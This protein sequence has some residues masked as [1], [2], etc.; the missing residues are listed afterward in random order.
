MLGIKIILD[1]ARRFVT[2]F[3]TSVFEPC[4]APAN[5]VHI[6]TTVSLTF[7]RLFRKAN[8]DYQLLRVC[9]SPCPHRTFRLPPRVFLRNFMFKIFNKIYQRFSVFVKIDTLCADLL[10][11]MNIL[12]TH[13]TIIVMVIMATNGLSL[14]WLGLSPLLP[15]L[16][17]LSMFL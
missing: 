6:F 1:G 16:P 17:S 5:S 13:V 15:W 10:T 7:S 11:Y 14:W 3:Q 9:P 12:A 8:S 4:L 2:A